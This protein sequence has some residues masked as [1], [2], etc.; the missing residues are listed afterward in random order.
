LLA[1]MGVVV[2]IYLPTFDDYF[3]GDD[4]LAFIDLTTKPALPYLWDVITYNDVNVYWRPFGQAYFLAIYAVFGLD[5]LYFHLANLIVFLATLVA[6]YAFCLRLGLGRLTALGAVALFGL[7]PNHAV[8]VAWTTNGPRLLATLLGLVSLLALQSAIAR[9]SWRWEAVAWVAMALAV[10]SDETAACLTPLPVIYAF[11]AQGWRPWRAH[12]ARVL[13]YGTLGLGITVLQMTAG[14]HQ[15]APTL[16]GLSEFGPGWHVLRQMWAL[17]AKLVLPT[18][19]GVG[20]QAITTAQWAAGAAFA[21][22]ALALLAFGGSRARFLVLWTVLALLPFSLWSVPIAPA[23][24]VYMAAL[25]FAI[26][27]SWSVVTA[28]ESVR[29]SD[30]WSK[31][32]PALAPVAAIPAVYALVLGM[33]FSMQATVQ[34]DEEFA[35]S[36]EPFRAL[37]LDLPRLLPEIPSGSR[38]VVYYSVWNGFSSWRDAVVQSVYKDATLQTAG[39]DWISTEG[40]S[41]QAQK[42]DVVVYYTPGGF[43]L[44]ARRP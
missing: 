17:A 38:I 23:R 14:L 22:F 33:G 5:P 11:M 20:L 26:I 28:V 19:D 4:F 7:V 1:L 29:R 2:L 16:I 9:R 35:R 6:I 41:P 31:F 42:G 27:A 10:L 18:H 30:F 39:F 40:S 3:H 15:T 44:P 25:P 8:S 24:Y 21:A 32:G 34:R 43:V 37:A 12:L 36:A 13:A